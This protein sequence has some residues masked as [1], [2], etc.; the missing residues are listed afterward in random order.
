VKSTDHNEPFSHLTPDTIL[1]AVEQAA[2]IHCTAYCLQLNSYINRV[3]ELETE[4]GERLVVKFYR[5]DRW[6]LTAL[7]EEHDF[8]RELADHDIP[9]VAPILLPS[10]R[11]LARHHDIYF[12]IY[13]KKSGRFFDEFSMEQWQKL[14]R[15]IGRMHAIASVKP[16]LSRPVLTPDKSTALHLK[17]LRASKLI[18]KRLQKSFTTTCSDLLDQIT[19]LFSSTKLVRL[20]G[21]CHFGNILHRAEESFLLIDFDDM[22]MGPAVQDFW[23]LL[24]G[25]KHDCHNEIENFLEG[26]DMFHH[27]NRRELALIEPLRAMRYIHFIAWCAHQAHDV[28]AA[29]NLVPGW[30][31]EPYWQQEILDM[32]TQISRIRQES[33]DPSFHHNSNPQYI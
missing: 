32:Q 4:E 3:Y 10:G 33:P 9:V 24:P 23:M 14:G 29:E 1:T 28:N 20:H 13:P 11:T 30:G 31:S 8:V 15:L 22:A 5:P 25:Y 21:D 17:F 19:P 27:F 18:P 6:P 16:C 12:A 2:G 7:D 26:Y